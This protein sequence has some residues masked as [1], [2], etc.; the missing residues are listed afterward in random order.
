[1][2]VCRG[3]LPARTLCLYPVRGLGP[4]EAY[5]PCAPVAAPRSIATATTT[6]KAPAQTIIT[7]RT[8]PR[9]ST[10]PT[11]RPASPGLWPCC[12]RFPVRQHGRG[13]TRNASYTPARESIGEQQSV[14]IVARGEYE[15]PALSLCVWALWELQLPHCNNTSWSEVLREAP[16]TIA[17]DIADLRMR[18]DGVPLWTL[19]PLPQETLLSTKRE[20][21]W[22]A[23]L[24]TILQDVDG[25]IRIRTDS[26][27]LVRPESSAR[28]TRDRTLLRK[29][30]L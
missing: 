21:N 3:A 10:Y 25:R 15:G 18:T 16:E 29:Q 22:E 27:P 6:T 24:V 4:C 30:V 14:V 26:N 7:A 8:A 23:R 28:A 19:A 20:T 13:I 2:Y 11:G 17:P 9:R 1:M 12:R 5:A